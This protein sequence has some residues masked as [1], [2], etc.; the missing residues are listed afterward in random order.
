APVP[1][2]RRAFG[3]LCLLGDHPGL[4]GEGA[5]RARAGVSVR[6]LAEHLPGRVTRY[7]AASSSSNAFVSSGGPSSASAVAVASAFAFFLKK[8]RN[9]KLC[10]T[11]SRSSSSFSVLLSR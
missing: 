10:W 7:G 6:R 1:P 8:P 2:H 3:D 4:R 5:D 9:R 11:A